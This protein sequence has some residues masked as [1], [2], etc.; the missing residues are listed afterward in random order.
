MIHF[1]GNWNGSHSGPWCCFKNLV[2]RMR[3]SQKLR[4]VTLCSHSPHAWGSGSLQSFCMPVWQASFDLLLFNVWVAHVAQIL[5]GIVGGR[6][7]FTNACQ[8]MQ[9]YLRNIRNKYK[10]LKQ[11]HKHIQHIENPAHR[12]KASSWKLVVMVAQLTL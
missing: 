4:M 5:I 12:T 11:L 8:H 3:N 1:A 6:Y 10:I 7:I 9:A 2:S